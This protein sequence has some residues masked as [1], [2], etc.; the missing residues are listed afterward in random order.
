MRACSS[1]GGAVFPYKALFSPAESHDQLPPGIPVSLRSTS[2][3]NKTL[4]PGNVYII[5]GDWLVDNDDQRERDGDQ[6]LILH[7][8][9]RQVNHIA[10]N[11]FC[12]ETVRPRAYLTTYGIVESVSTTLANISPND[13]SPVSFVMNHSNYNLYVGHDSKL[14]LH[15][16]SC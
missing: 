12:N 7:F 5:H 3:L 10:P 13:S 14:Q 6:K 9:N 8:F 11:E 4:E 16:N 1:T 2:F 15:G